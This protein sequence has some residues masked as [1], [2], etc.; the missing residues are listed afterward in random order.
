MSTEY[1]VHGLGT[2]NVIRDKKRRGR[3]GQGS[4]SSKKE[5]KRNQYTVSTH[6]PIRREL[7]PMRLRVEKKKNAV[8]VVVVV[9]DYWPTIDGASSIK[10][11]R[12]GRRP[13]THLPY[14]F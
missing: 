8:V 14:S 7:A 6:P 11:G 9:V 10:S 2:C 13:L 3:A 4:S 1:T 5:K 12:V